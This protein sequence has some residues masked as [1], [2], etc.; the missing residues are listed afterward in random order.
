MTNEAYPFYFKKLTQ[1]AYR[2]A[3]KNE[4]SDM[5][6]DCNEDFSQYSDDELTKFKQQIKKE[7]DEFF[8]L[9]LAEDK[10]S[11]IEKEKL[12]SLIIKHLGL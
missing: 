9:M 11:D 12:F 5:D 10:Y 7:I 4:G 6:L 8:V 1:T 3:S 2:H